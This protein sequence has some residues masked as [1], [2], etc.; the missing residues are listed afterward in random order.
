MKFSAATCRPNSPETIAS[1]NATKN[2]THAAIRRPRSM[3]L[4]T[5][6]MLAFRP[7]ERCREVRHIS[8]RAVKAT[9]A[10][11]PTNSNPRGIGAWIRAPATSCALATPEKRMSPDQRRV[12]RGT[13]GSETPLC[14]LK[15][16]TGEGDWYTSRTRRCHVRSKA[17]AQSERLQACQSSEVP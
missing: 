8:V 15:I 7:L 3:L 1:T 10:P 4:G 9:V 14:P 5:V 11:A 2:P 6:A 16:R 12:S 13:I 17:E